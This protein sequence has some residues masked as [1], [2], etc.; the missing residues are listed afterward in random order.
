VPVCR[1]GKRTAE[2]DPLHEIRRRGYEYFWVKIFHA[3]PWM[4]GADGGDGKTF[5][6]GSNQRSYYKYHDRP[7]VGLLAPPIP[8]RQGRGREY[9]PY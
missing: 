7:A 9:N 4:I 1:L 5:W 6:I 2:K 3:W 8:Q